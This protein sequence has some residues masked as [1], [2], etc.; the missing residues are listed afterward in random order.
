MESTVMK[1]LHDRLEK[2][3]AAAREAPGTAAQRIAKLKTLRKQIGRW[4]NDNQIVDNKSL[5]DAAMKWANRL[6]ASPTRAYSALK[7]VVREAVERR[8][9]QRFLLEQIEPF[10]V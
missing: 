2:Q 1:S 10:L 5:Y 9:E 4:N 6:A 8:I 3:R 7:Q